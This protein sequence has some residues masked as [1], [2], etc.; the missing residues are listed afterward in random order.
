[1]DN[2]E[3]AAL[4]TGRANTAVKAIKIMTVAAVITAVVLLIVTT[5]LSAMQN[6]KAAFICM[7]VFVCLVAA[8]LIAVSAAFIYAKINLNKLK[9]LG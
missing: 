5:V 8:L 1:M 2:E 9:K 4:L 7:I 6:V 3:Y